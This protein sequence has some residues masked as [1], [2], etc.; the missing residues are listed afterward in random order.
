[1]P[2]ECDGEAEDERPCCDG[3][4]RDGHLKGCELARVLDVP[5]ELEMGYA[6]EEE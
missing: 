1:M 4:K 6:A 3:I 2:V 5:A